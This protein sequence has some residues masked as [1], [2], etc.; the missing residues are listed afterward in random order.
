MQKVRPVLRVVSGERG[1]EIACGLLVLLNAQGSA[2]CVPA[3][4]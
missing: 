1:E 3:V 4:R 2:L